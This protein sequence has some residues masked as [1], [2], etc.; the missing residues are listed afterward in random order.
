MSNMFFDRMGALYLLIRVLVEPLT[1][2]PNIYLMNFTTYIFT[3]HVRWCVG[4]QRR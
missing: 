4:S 1:K 3:I 2:N